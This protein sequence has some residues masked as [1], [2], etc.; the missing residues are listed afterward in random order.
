MLA[1]L[2]KSTF[3]GQLV[4]PR[5]WG[6]AETPEGPPLYQKGWNH[7]CDSGL[8]VYG[9]SRYKASYEF[10]QDWRLVDNRDYYSGWKQGYGYCRWYTYN[11]VR[12]WRE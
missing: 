10:T 7:G 11:W 12:P 2:E 4:K 9:N 6:M 5:P 3:A 8:N 1:E